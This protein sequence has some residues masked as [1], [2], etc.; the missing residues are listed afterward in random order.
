M[1]TFAPDEQE[2]IVS[3]ANETTDNPYVFQLF[4]PQNDNEA[5]VKAMM[6]TL[7]PYVKEYVEEQFY[8]QIDDYE[9]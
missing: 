1:S 9:H 2:M 7:T 5:W 4:V 8:K 3:M 6:E